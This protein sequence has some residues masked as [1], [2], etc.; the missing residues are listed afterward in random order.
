[1]TFR[2]FGFMD[3]YCTW[4]RL[5]VFAS[6]IVTDFDDAAFSRKLVN[7]GAQLDF[8]IVVF[9]LMN[10]TFSVGVARAYEKGLPARNE[11]MISL[12]LM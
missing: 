1:V 7:F 11:F 8:R 9:S 10:S 5:A 6:G 2:R 3:L 4:A 12:K